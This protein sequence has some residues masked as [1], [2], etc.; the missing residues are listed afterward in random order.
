MMKPGPAKRAKLPP[1]NGA[2]LG[3]AICVR[4]VSIHGIK[5]V[6]A[7]TAQETLSL[8]VYEKKKLR[9]QENPT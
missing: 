1:K 2:H 3:V 7:K 4:C 8:R 9:N 6:F 5:F